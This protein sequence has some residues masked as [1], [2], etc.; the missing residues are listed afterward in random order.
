M[1]DKKKITK[2][3]EKETIKKKEVVSK[4]K[5]TRVLVKEDVYPAIEIAQILDISS[6]DLFRMR[7]ELSITDGT[8]L[9]ISE[10]QKLYQ[11]IKGR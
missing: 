5:P 7:Q 6:F 4:V 2:K 9:T 1:A 10:F 8:Y 3:E 11:Q